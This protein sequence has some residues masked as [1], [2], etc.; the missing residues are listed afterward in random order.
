SSGSDAV[1]FGKSVSFGN[2]YCLFLLSG[3]LAGSIKTG[4]A[5]PG[6][7]GVFERFV[8]TGYVP[9]QNTW[10]HVA[11]TYDGSLVTVYANGVALATA[12][13]TGTISDSGAPFGIGGRSGGLLFSGLIDEVEVFNRA[14]S[15][16][17]IVNIYLADSAGKCRT[18]TT[19][20]SNMVGWWPGDG[21]TKDIQGGNNGQL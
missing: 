1:Y 12:T 17:E 14:L 6:Q 5:N 2:D 19:A 16:N 10:T 20:P 11:L 13:K 9:P 18:C 21:N 3:Q 4:T 8:Y 15:P 7:P